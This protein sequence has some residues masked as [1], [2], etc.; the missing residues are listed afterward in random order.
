MKVLIEHRDGFMRRMFKAWSSMC[1]VSDFEQCTQ[2]AFVD[3]GP[4]DALILQ[5]DRPLS[6]SQIESM[7]VA[8]GLWRDG[9]NYPL[10]LDGGLRVVGVRRSVGNK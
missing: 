4:D 2:Q 6:R 7:K 3:V 9:T 1:H 5:A 10:I 8:L